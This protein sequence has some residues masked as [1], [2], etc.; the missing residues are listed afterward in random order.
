MSGGS[1]SKTANI[2]QVSNGATFTAATSSPLISLS[3]GATLTGTTPNGFSGALLS[4]AG[5][6][7]P[8]GTAPATA[9]FGGPLLSVTGGT[10][11]MPRDLF[12]GAIA[13]GTVI[14]NDAT[15]AFVSLS[16]GAHTVG[17]AAFTQ[18]FRLTGLNTNPLADTDLLPVASIFNL[19]TDKPLQRSGVGAFLSLSN[20]A[21]LNTNEGFFLDTA[22]LNASAPLLDLSG[23]STM[24]TAFDA[25]NLNQRAKLT[26][27]VQPLVKINGGTLTINGNAVRVNNSALVTGDLF[28]IAN[29][30]RININGANNAA[31]FLSGTSAVNITGFVVNFTGV[32]N[33]LNIANTLCPA[34]CFTTSSGIN[35]SLQGGATSAQIL[36]GLGTA[37]NNPGGNTS[38]SASAAVVIINGTTSKVSLP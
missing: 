32:G 12:L 24:T 19:G 21:T 36:G 30:G 7:G 26:S 18:L 3:N 5:F 17:S 1:L 28:S 37:I 25:I 38:P 14:A 35:V 22:L 8:S 27:L 10:L 2:I 13:G 20:G 31:L 23:G 9:T 11:N 29:G 33:Q 34:T 15:Q 4:I 16:G 6:G